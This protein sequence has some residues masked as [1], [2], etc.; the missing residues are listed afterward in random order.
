M[1]IT[2]D[3]RIRIRMKM[4]IR[5]RIHG[6]EHYG[7]PCSVLVRQ[8]AVIAGIHIILVIAWIMCP[9]NCSHIILPIAWI[10]DYPCNCVD[11]IHAITLMDIYKG[12]YD[13]TSL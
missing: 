2:I 13:P 10:M 3:T 11:N 5:T 12:F 7:Y 6:E 8:N 1:P 4:R 9:C